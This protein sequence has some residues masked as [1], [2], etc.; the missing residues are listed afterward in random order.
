MGCDASPRTRRIATVYPVIGAYRVAV[1]AELHRRAV[2]EGHHHEFHADPYNPVDTVELANFDKV[3]DP[4]DR[5]HFNWIPDVRN[6]TIGK[7]LW[8]SGVVRIAMRRDLDTVI[9][10]G[11]CWHL[12]TWAGALVAR[13]TGKK[14]VYWTHGIY[15]TESFIRRLFRLSFLRLA[16]HVMFYGSHARQLAEAAGL[17]PKRLSTIHN[18]LDVTEQRAVRSTLTE[19]EL[20]RTRQATFR[21]PSRPV[22]LFIGRLIAEKRLD[23][24]IEAAEILATRN[25]PVNVLLIGGGPM[26]EALRRSAVTR[27]VSD[28]VYFFGK[29]YEEAKLGPAIAMAD[30]C[31]SPGAIG[32]TCMHALAYGT[33]VIT[34]DDP[35]AQG[36]ECE[37]VVPGVTG[38]LFRRDDPVSLANTISEWL[39]A[40]SDRAAIRNACVAEVDRRWTPEAV[41][42]AIHASIGLSPISQSAPSCRKPGDSR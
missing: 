22:L 16:T 13:I 35:S 29:C 19:S 7:W 38:A 14:V 15:G 40:A 24:L 21:C 39:A 18:C 41:A 10:L 25:T 37:A 4:T 28:S 5:N 42:E 31:V 11:V 3:S 32:L 9:F 23:L 17:D 1:F 26:E 27:H 8:Q 20:E 12:S 6:H 33:P 36:P 30:L 2:L 34:H